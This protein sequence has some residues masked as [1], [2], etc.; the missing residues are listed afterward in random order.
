MTNLRI[1]AVHLLKGSVRHFFHRT[2]IH[3]STRCLGRLLIRNRVTL[4]IDVG[5]NQG[6]YA[7]DIRRLGYRGRIVSFEPL[8]EA[9]AIL[10][11]RAAT[12][13][14]WDHYDCAL[15]SEEREATL[16]RSNNLESSSLL[17]MLPAHE[18][19]APDALCVGTETIK[20]RRLDSLFAD[21]ARP[22][23]VVFL[24]IDAQGYEVP[25]LDG[26]AACLDRI[27]GVQV[28]ASLVPLYEGEP[29]IETVFTRLRQLGYTP[30]DIEPTFRD[31]HS[32]NLLQCDAVFF[33]PATTEPATH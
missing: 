20:V 9:Q 18:T 16:H 19:A 10:S 8:S 27:A 7:T 23:D 26:A 11:R 12:D 5:A 3:F 14:L 31:P 32:F 33:R 17:K 22:D 29:C 6:Q 13:P 25:V 21:L 28:E 15:G 1:R 24:K 4:V 2:G 30:V